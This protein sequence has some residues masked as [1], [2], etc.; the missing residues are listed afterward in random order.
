MIMIPEGVSSPSI[1][2]YLN[3]QLIVCR[4]LSG[5][6]IFTLVTSHSA[7]YIVIRE[8]NVVMRNW[9]KSIW[10]QICNVSRTCRPGLA[11]VMMSKL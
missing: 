1:A 5:F 9:V 11:Y 8:S 10:L 6:G 3:T 4:Y 7:E 2:L